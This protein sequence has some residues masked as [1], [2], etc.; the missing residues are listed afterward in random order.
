[1]IDALLVSKEVGVN[2]HLSY[3]RAILEKLLLDSLIVLSEAVIDDLIENTVLS[4]LVGFKV[5]F[6]FASSLGASKG[7]ALLRDETLALAPAESASD[8][9]TLASVVTLVTTDDLLGR[10]L[11]WLLDLLANAIGHSRY[12]NCSV[13]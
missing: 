2:N 9:T 7:K 4:A 1:V 13:C 6:H 11:H 10:E 8:I 12:G 5:I 3:D